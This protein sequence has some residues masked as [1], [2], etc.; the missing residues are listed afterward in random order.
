MEALEA[1][2]GAVLYAGLGVRLQFGSFSAAL[3]ARRAALK[4]L[5]EEREQQGSEGLENVR[6]ALTLSYASRLW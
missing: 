6:A 3:G 5:N 4:L 2:G 1:S